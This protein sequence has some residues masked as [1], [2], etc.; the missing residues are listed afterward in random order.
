MNDRA[1]LDAARYR[2][3]S[4]EGG[5]LN[6]P[7][8][9]IVPY[10]EGDGVG[11]EIWEATS[12]VLRTAVRCAYN[13]ERSVRFV[14]V[15]AGLKAQI[16]CGNPLP[17]ET[18]AAFREYVVGIKGPLET[19][20]G[21]GIRSLNVAIRQA[22]DLYACV[23]PVKYRPGVPSPLRYPERV[24]VVIFRENTEDVY[25]GIEYP[26]GSGMVDDLRELIGPAIAGDSAVGLKIMSREASKRLVRKAIQYALDN[27]RRS[28]TLVHKGNI[29]KH[30]EGAFRNWGYEVARDEFPGR[31][32]EEGD[33]KEGHGRANEG[34]IVI[35]D[36]IA[37]NMMQQL[38]LHPE[39]YD[40]IATPNLNGDYI[41]D[42]VAAEVGGLGIAPG[43]N[44]GTGCAV[45]EATHGT[46]PDL[47]GKGRANPCSLI[48][49]GVMMLEH[50]GWKE[51]AS[52]LEKA[53]EHVI[54]GGVLTD[55][56]AGG[57][58][59]S[60][61]EFAQALA[62]AVADAGAGW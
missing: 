22:L 43:A 2:K 49:S 53:L 56:L 19:P 9:A 23:R 35:K 32:V 3:I 58:G 62:G 29:M 50:L 39:E 61:W 25:A 28:V 45:F 15:L 18:L 6:V 13:G 46:A 38:L 24:D 54:G 57:R 30:T 14:E 7:D 27:G 11:P 51:A 37:D 26:A 36:R 41:S 48:L 34:T 47:A 33:S 10:I 59:V 40:V 16:Q 31:V 1:E 12:M 44:V 8:H 4:I 17:A 5:R 52:L 60:T 21:G 42:L 55:D 20:V